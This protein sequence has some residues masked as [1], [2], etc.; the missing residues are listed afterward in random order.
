MTILQKLASISLVCAVAAVTLQPAASVA[1]EKAVN[2][3]PAA[4][5]P[6]P[7]EP[8]AKVNGTV[9]TRGEIDRAVNIFLAQNRS[10]QK[11]T[12]DQLQQLHDSALEQM[13]AAEVLYQAGQK[14]APKDAEKQAEEKIN[15]S[16]ARFQSPAEFDAVLKSSGLTEAELKDLTRK[17]IVINALVEKEV[18]DK[19]T[20]SDADAEKFYKDNIDKFKKPQSVKASHIL[21]GVDPKATDEEKKKAKE[22]AEGLLKQIKEGKDF[23]AL[24]KENSTCPSSAQGGDLGFFG[25]GQ[26]VPP[27]EAAAFAMKPG[28]ISNVV[29][30]QFGYH[31]IKLTDRKPAETTSL[32]EVK[33]KIKDYLKGQ[34]VQQAVGQYIEGLKAKAKI[35][36]FAEEAPAK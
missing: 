5:Q 32:E 18:A 4:A 9:I 13:I 22:K 19:I 3:P 27:F 29:E 14:V 16:K 17:D 31:I 35:E 8:L 2:A 1:E 33:P 34:K 36:R 20:I 21:I 24:A 26:M 6:S 12:P 15:E 23:A 10:P 11:P 28:E 30:T 25:K 7:N